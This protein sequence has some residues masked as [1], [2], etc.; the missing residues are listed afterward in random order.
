MHGDTVSKN[1]NLVVLQI[2]LGYCSDDN[3]RYNSFLARIKKLGG[4]G[5]MK[6]TKKEKRPHYK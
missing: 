1:L 6:Y 5:G 4:G 3:N 2:G